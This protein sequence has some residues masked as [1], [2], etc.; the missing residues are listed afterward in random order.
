MKGILAVL[1]IVI[2]INAQAA[3]AG[4]FR[5]NLNLASKHFIDPPPG[6]D[7]YTERHGG[8][9]GELQ[10]TDEIYIHAGYVKEN[11]YGEPGKFLGIG[12]RTFEFKYAAIGPEVTF[13]NGY[14]K[15][16]DEGEQPN[17]I[18]HFWGIFTAFDFGGHGPKLFYAGKLATLQYQFKF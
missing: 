4:D 17:D 1:I 12:A 14:I 10:I 9:A 16:A 8:L 13:A 7:H 5:L 15:Y 3:H 2:S 11:S 6:L 18:R